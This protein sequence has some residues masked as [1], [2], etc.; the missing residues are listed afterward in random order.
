[1]TNQ[2]VAALTWLVVTNTASDPDLPANVLTYDLLDGPEGASIDTN[3]IITWLPPAAQAPG[4]YTLTTIATDANPDAV[5][6]QQLSATNSFTVTVNEATSLF[7]LVTASD[8]G[9]I[10]LAP[11]GARYPSNTLVQVTA[12]GSAGW[13]FLGW[14][15]D[16]QGTNPVMEIIM[17]GPKWV[18]AV[19]GTWLNTPVSGDG[20]VWISPTNHLCPWG[21]T[22]Q[23]LGIPGSK[24]YFSRWNVAS[25]A[26]TNVAT[27]NPLKYFVSEPTLTFEA[28]FERLQAGKASFTAIPDGRG[29]IVVTPHTNSYNVGD[30]VHVLAV[31]EPG[32]SFQGWTGDETS[33][34]MSLDVTLRRSK[35]ITAHFSKRPRL[36]IL[37]GGRQPRD[38][39]VRLNLSGEAGTAYRI[40]G[41][42][43]FQTWIEMGVLNCPYGTAQITDPAGTALSSRFYRAES[44]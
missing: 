2:A 3:G 33:T 23:L 18:K 8:A 26:S 35:V 24:S 39:G 7:A 20:T 6:D 38:A 31:P 44:P 19:F 16:L 42:A 36:E 30:I 21:T 25:G 13:T 43:D 1:L 28:V 27:A 11:A 32:Q 37:F 5:N 29:E 12:R 34:N 22:V 14:T 15:G 10:D 4:S 17:N 41:S 9:T 40:L